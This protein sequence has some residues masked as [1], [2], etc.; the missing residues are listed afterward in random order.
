MKIHP[1][2]AAL[3]IGCTASSAEAG[4]VTHVANTA[5][6]PT[7]QRAIVD[8]D[9]NLTG[10]SDAG[11]QVHYDA[12]GFSV[13]TSGTYS[14]LTTGAYDTYTFL[15][16]PTFAASQPLTNGLKGNDEFSSFGLGVSAF[17]Y[18][19]QA[20]VHYTLVTTGFANGDAGFASTTIGGS[21]A[22]TPTTAATAVAGSPNVLTFTGSTTASTT[23]DRL[24]ED[25]S[26]VS[27]VGDR[28]AYQ[29]FRF[30]VTTTGAYSFLTTGDF[31]TFDFLY[32]SF[33]PSAPLSNA[34]SGDDDMFGVGTSGFM[35]DLI[36]G[37][38]YTFVTTGFGNGDFGFFSNTIGGP[39]A[40]VAAAVAVPEPEIL[41][42]LTIGAGA[43]GWRTRRR[44]TA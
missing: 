16:A 33:D 41:A 8:R 12:Y 11:T 17:E 27:T 26:T 39:G 43:M 20:G 3:V 23:Y 36:A 29:T 24:V 44:R 15:Y 13:A 14:F 6:D 18:A 37:V 40:I 35:A 1:I 22:I 31:D 42:L 34:K 28:V 9:G 19:L 7:Y 4:I 32:A 10:L 30:R 2:V 38:D 21:G 25:L 5:V